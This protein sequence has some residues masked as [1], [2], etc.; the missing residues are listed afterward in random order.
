[1]SA[2]GIPRLAVLLVLAGA[3]TMSW[4]RCGESDRDDGLVSEVPAAEDD[5]S[6]QDVPTVE[7]SPPTVETN[8]DAL[9]DA[10][11]ASGEAGADTASDDALAGD[12]A[13]A[14]ADDL[15]IPTAPAELEASNPCATPGVYGAIPPPAGLGASTASLDGAVIGEGLLGQ[16]KIGSG[17]IIYDRYMLRAA[18][19][20]AA[21]GDIQVAPNGEAAAV[22]AKTGFV[23]KDLQLTLLDRAMSVSYE[24]Y[25]HPLVGEAIDFAAG[26]IEKRYGLEG[27]DFQYAGYPNGELAS[28]APTF[29]AGDLFSLKRSAEPSQAQSYPAGAASLDWGF[30]WHCG[31]V[32]ASGNSGGPLLI[33]GRLAGIH[34]GGTLD[35]YVGDGMIPLIEDEISQLGTTVDGWY[36]N[37]NRN[38]T[39]AFTSFDSELGEVVTEIASPNHPLFKLPWNRDPALKRRGTT[40]RWMARPSE[41][42]LVTVRAQTEDG[43]VSLEYAPYG[44]GYS[45]ED[46]DPTT[47]VHRF[48]LGDDALDGAWKTITRD[49][50]ADLAAAGRTVSVSAIER[51]LVVGAGRIADLHL[52]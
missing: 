13:T 32:G 7:D 46:S 22:V 19:A 47:G 8:E 40:V 39:L 4:S 3:T 27:M 36:S 21:V 28:S 43:L 38:H 52:E 48:G 37:R 33:D 5:S 41:S 18:H 49:V 16:R 17:T 11:D 25:R 20:Q 12:V 50:E 6:A 34:K 31:H 29:G 14:Y 9:P 35:Q 2:G 1:M 51:V 10:A 23:G 44:E 45:S 42:M 15:V 24:L 30:L 26:Q